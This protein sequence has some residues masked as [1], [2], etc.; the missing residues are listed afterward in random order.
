MLVAF[1]VIYPAAYRLVVESPSIGI[2]PG[3]D[4]VNSYTPCV[5]KI[6]QLDDFVP[7]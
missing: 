6:K 7:E 4:G 5:V 3:M 2:L 1:K